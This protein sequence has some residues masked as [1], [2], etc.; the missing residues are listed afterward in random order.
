MPAVCPI[1]SSVRAREVGAP[2]VGGGRAAGG[3][4]QVIGFHMR[5]LD[6][7]LLNAVPSRLESPAEGLD[8]G[9]PGRPGRFLINGTPSAQAN[10][11]I[12]QPGDEVVLETPGG[13]GFGAPQ[14]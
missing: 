4:G 1:A 2:R 13:G 9:I 10:K 5:T 11:M 8:G 7:W 6:P 3:D 12:M 14:G